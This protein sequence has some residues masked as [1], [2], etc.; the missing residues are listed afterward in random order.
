M[1]AGPSAAVAVALSERLH[2]CGS[3]KFCGVNV[4]VLGVRKDVP[5]M[6]EVLG[7]DHSVAT[8]F[9]CGWKG[10]LTATT[11]PPAPAAVDSSVSM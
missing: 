3:E 5:V 8:T 11:R 1:S 9:A 7:T 10:R 4:S 2:V 6:Y